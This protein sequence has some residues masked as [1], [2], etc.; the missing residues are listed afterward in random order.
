MF[1]WSNGLVVVYKVLIVSQDSLLLILLLLL[2]FACPWRRWLPQASPHHLPA[3]PSWITYSTY[4]QL[5]ECTNL[6]ETTIC[7]APGTPES[8]VGPHGW[9]DQDAR[10]LQTLIQEHPIQLGRPKDVKEGMECVIFTK[11]IT[12][13]LMATPHF[14]KLTPKAWL[15]VTPLLMAWKPTFFISWRSRTPPSVMQP[16]APA[17]L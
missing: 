3:Q 8:R 5:C 15:M 16:T 10:S 9:V 11:K 13:K 17:D 6:K 14:P 1:G 12:R 7:D 2:L 4:L